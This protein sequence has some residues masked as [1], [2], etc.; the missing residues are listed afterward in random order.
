VAND[1]IDM[2]VVADYNILAGVANYQMIIDSLNFYTEEIDRVIDIG[3]TLTAESV[4]PKMNQKTFLKSFMQQYCLV[5]EIDETTK[6][7]TFRFFN[8]LYDNI[9]NAIDYSSKVVI[10]EGRKWS[11][12]SKETRLGNYGQKN[13]LRW[14]DDETLN[15][16]DYGM[17]TIEVADESLEKE[18]TMFQLPFAATE[19]AT[20][21]VSGV[22]VARIPFF[23]PDGSGG[24][25]QVHEPAPRLL[26]I[27]RD[28]IPIIYT[29]G[30]SISPIAQENSAIGKFIDP[31]NTL[32]M[33]FNNNLISRYYSGLIKMLFESKRFS[34]LM[35]L[36]ASEVS[37]FDFFT[38]R[39]IKQL[40]GYF[41]VNKL[42]NFIEGKLISVPIVRL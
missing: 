24:Y 5:P 34:V 23:E 21:P 17:G 14:A 39:Y 36:T 7:L 41:Y 31:G 8:E 12:E 42:P 10:P 26:Y 33:G 20:L 38:P 1:V 29:D 18:Y 9:P 2:Y 4:L 19:S 28:V 35:K 6:T 30:A 22:R 25:E 32:N 37:G 15:D 11:Y 40:G 13:Y 16:A 27:Q 3:D